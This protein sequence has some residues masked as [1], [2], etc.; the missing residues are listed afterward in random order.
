MNLTPLF[1]PTWI[2]YAFITLFGYPC[3]ILTQYGIYFSTFL[4]VQATL[5][6]IVKLYKTISIKYNL[7][8]NITIFSSIAHGFF[9]VLTARMVNDPN[10]TQNKKPKSTLLKSKS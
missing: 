3:Y 7:K 10:V 8:N 4:V 5:T 9:N 2:S 6:L 1:T